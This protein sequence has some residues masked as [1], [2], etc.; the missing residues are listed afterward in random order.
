VIDVM[1]CDIQDVGARF[2]TYISTIAEIMEACAE[3]NL[4]V[5]LL[6]R[7][8][9][10]RGLQ[11]EGPIREPDLKSFV[12]WAP[13]PVSHGMTIAELSTMTNDE[14]WLK[15]GV[16]VQLDIVPM[17]G[18]KRDM[19]FDETGLKWIPPSPNMP[20]LNTAIVYPGLCLIEG[21]NISEGRGTGSPFLL[22]GA[23]WADADRIIGQLRT[24]GLSGLAFGALQYTPHEIPNFA[25]KPKYEGRH[26]SGVQVFVTERDTIEPVRL[27]IAMIAAFKKIHPEEMTF[28]E[29]AFD[30]L[31]GVTKVRQHLEAGLGPDVI[32]REWADELTGFGQLRRKYLLYG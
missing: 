22:I 27:G 28:R 18:W 19:W 8:N 14:G 4:P 17:A 23:P 16:K 13:I 3:N 21:T 11:Y 10:I 30:R 6:D 1:I 7:P 5:I 24:H 20:T 15:N 2:Y 31:I 25:S 9:P 26:C 29:A 12:G 32:C